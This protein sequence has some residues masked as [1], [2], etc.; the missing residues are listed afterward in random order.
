MSTDKEPLEE[1]ETRAYNV[2]RVIETKSKIQLFERHGDTTPVEVFRKDRVNEMEHGDGVKVS[3]TRY[4]VA[5]NKGDLRVEV[6]QSKE[7]KN[8]SIK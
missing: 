4:F 5:R 2:E 1:G 3:G 8:V 7:G 6:T